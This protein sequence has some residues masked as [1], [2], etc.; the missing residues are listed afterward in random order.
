MV[1]VLLCNTAEE[2]VRDFLCSRNSAHRE[3]HSSNVCVCKCKTDYALI[4]HDPD[5]REHLHFIRL[6]EF[7]DSANEVLI[8]PECN[9]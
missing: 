6:R 2:R 4:P 8:L 1:Q 9:F 5:P 7:Q 3:L